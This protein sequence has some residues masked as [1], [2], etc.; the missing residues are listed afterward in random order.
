ML[1]IKYTAKFRKEIKMC[2]RQ[3]RSM[4]KFRRIILALCAGEPLL[5]HNKDHKLSGD[6]AGYRE[7]HIEPDWWLIYK[8]SDEQLILYR[9]GTHADLFGK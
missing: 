4:P 2:I 5:P 6:Y 1:K 7:C 8:Q 3:G 9:T